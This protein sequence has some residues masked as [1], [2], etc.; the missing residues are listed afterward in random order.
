MYTYFLAFPRRDT[1]NDGV[2]IVQNNSGDTGKHFLEMLLEASNIFAVT[3]YLQQIF[4]TDEVESENKEIL[5]IQVAI[6]GEC[7]YPE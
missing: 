6:L 5:E 2:V 7:L 3:D 4:I 1:V